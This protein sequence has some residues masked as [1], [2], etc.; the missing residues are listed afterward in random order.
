L[1][2][3]IKGDGGAVAIGGNGT[4]LAPGCWDMDT[5]G[6]GAVIGDG[7][8]AGETTINGEAVL[9][10][11][12]VVF[13]DGDKVRLCWL[14][15]SIASRT[16]SKEVVRWSKLSIRRMPSPYTWLTHGIGEIIGDNGRRRESGL[17]ESLPLESVLVLLLS[18]AGWNEAAFGFKRDVVGVTGALTGGVWPESDES[19]GVLVR[20][21][22]LKHRIRHWAEVT[23]Q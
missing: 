4:K 21:L 19:V 15:C 10:D 1:D 2:A 11:A 8:T 3:T 17:F 13:K 9:S 23:L 16:D 12:E 7:I 5:T 22:P 18:E 20:K 14:A 6:L